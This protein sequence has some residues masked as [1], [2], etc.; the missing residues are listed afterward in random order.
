MLV[1]QAQI[2]LFCQTIYLASNYIPN[3]LLHGLPNYDFLAVSKESSYNYI[4]HIYCS[5]LWAQGWRKI[6]IMTLYGW[7]YNYVTGFEKR[8]HF[9]QNAKFL[10][11]SNCHHT[12]TTEATDFGLLSMIHQIQ[13]YQL[14]SQ[15]VSS[16]LVAKF[17]EQETYSWSTCILSSQKSLSWQE[18]ARLLYNSCHGT[19]FTSWYIIIMT[20]HALCVYMCK[21]DLV[22]ECIIVCA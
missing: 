17:I 15:R 2:Q 12:K 3:E 22:I 21:Q 9:T 4:I 7:G 16:G 10:H 6:H 13:Y 20:V 18:G 11:F 5:Y 19:N 1:E 14:G 8:A